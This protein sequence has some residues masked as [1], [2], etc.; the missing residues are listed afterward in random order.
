[1]LQLIRPH[2][3]LF[4]VVLVFGLVFSASLT[5]AYV[6]GDDASMIAYH[7]L[8]R[9][10]DVQPPYNPYHSMTDAWLGLLPAR[11]PLLR[12]AAISLSAASAVV[13]TLLILALA[14]DGLKPI[15]E[16]SP[17]ASALA[18]LAALPELFYLGLLFTPSLPA[19]SL[20][21]LAHLVARRALPALHR[22]ASGS[23]AG[24][25]GLVLAAVLFG[26]GAACRWDTVT[27]GAII[28]ADLAL[29]ALKLEDGSDRLS[30]RLGT[31]MLWGTMALFAFFAAV[32]V[33][34]YGLGDVLGVARF[35]TSFSGSRPRFSGPA[36][37]ALQSLL[38]PGFGLF[39]LLGLWSL[40]RRIPRLAA[41]A[42]LG[43]LLAVPWM[44]TGVPKYLIVAIP[45]LVTAFILG[46]SQTWELPGKHTR[47]LA[48]LLAV[49]CLILPWVVG[50]RIAYE[51]SSW[52][53]GFEVRPFTSSLTVNRE[54]AFGSGAGAP[55]PE[56]PRPMWGHLHVLL[57]GEW[58][59]LIQDLALE[60][61]RVILAAAARNLPI[62]RLRGSNGFDTAELAARGYSTRD[63]VSRPSTRVPFLLERYFQHPRGG[64]ITYLRTEQPEI[65]S[66]VAIL[67]SLSREYGDRVIVLGYPSD[68]RSL[69]R[70]AP[71]ALE[72]LG[73]MSSFLN[74][75]ELRH[76]SC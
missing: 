50:V 46:F 70:C 42:A 1:M 17:L 75:P 61:S 29:H 60:R 67:E 11:E 19:M 26:T 4:T 9:V 57:G 2:L 64:R 32:I 24:L 27:Y 48:R 23:Y 59:R 25:P 55:T 38:T 14:F 35:G 45:G 47:V 22:R 71:R 8:G 62:L 72:P 63:S 28:T 5:F 39:T 37:A 74:I 21:L 18:V 10:A 51:D 52:G 3:W 69:Y 53:P 30:R 20:I 6:E 36:L 13:M 12:V 7:A 33:S 34:G 73:P 49:L 68:L 54:P 58:R 56:G 16:I 66:S 15:P 76:V 44:V 40:A 41:T 65:L 43:L 31:A